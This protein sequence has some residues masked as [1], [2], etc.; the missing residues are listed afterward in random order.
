VL[1]QLKTHTNLDH[2]HS[3]H[4][5]LH[6]E[7]TKSLVERERERECVCVF[8]HREGRRGENNNNTRMSMEV[9]PDVTRLRG[10]MK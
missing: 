6:E 3:H 10:Q 2:R 5:L 9:H 8:M 4:P 1:W 7:V